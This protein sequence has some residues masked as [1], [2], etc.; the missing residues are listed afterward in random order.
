MFP[1]PVDVGVG[2][3]EAALMYVQ[4]LKYHCMW[5]WRYAGNQARNRGLSTPRLFF[6]QNSTSIGRVSIKKP[7]GC[8]QICKPW[9][10]VQNEPYQNPTAGSETGPGRM[11]QLRASLYF[12]P[13]F[14]VID[15]ESWQTAIGIRAGCSGRRCWFPFSRTPPSRLLKCPN[16]P[17]RPFRA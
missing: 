17:L 11:D 14:F 10:C 6:S 16:H 5:Y 9:A 13:C 3:N 8:V 12:L 1:R 15:K 2:L 4:V 7:S